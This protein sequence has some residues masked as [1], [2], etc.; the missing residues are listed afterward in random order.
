MHWLLL[1]ETNKNP[2]PGQFFIVG[3]LV[4]TD[5]QIPLVTAVVDVIR[6]DCGY[7]DGDSLK[8]QLSARP[9]HVSKEQAT[10]AKKRVIEA[11]VKLDVRMIT[12]V[13]LHDV[14]KT[15]SDRER[16]EMGL[17]TVVWAYHRLLESEQTRGAFLIDRDDS[18]HPYL[19]QLFQ[20]GVL[21]AGK[22]TRL[23]VRDRVQFMGMTSNNASHLSSAVDIALGGFRFCV[24]ASS[25]DEEHGAHLVA[26]SIFGELSSMLWSVQDGDKRRIGGHGFIAR[27]KGGP[28]WA[29][30]NEHYI[31]LRR[32]LAK[33]ANGDPEE[34]ASSD[35]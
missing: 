8:F 33:Y 9:D 4:L 28:R 27:P 32:K 14:A 22:S 13:I 20:H 26:R 25:L 31:E 24:N 11:L 35:A 2:S 12:Y 16:M 21:P 30:Y 1:D 17:N 6:Q 10:D 18:L 7:R 23:P 19:A 15:K 3:G 34:G 29:P 5:E